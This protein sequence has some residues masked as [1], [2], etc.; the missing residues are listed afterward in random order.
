MYVCMYVCI[1]ACMY[2]CIS[3]HDAR[4]RS[5]LIQPVLE[6]ELS[7]PPLSASMSMRNGDLSLAY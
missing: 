4:W 7:I 6:H 3:E 1:C 2:V 5:P